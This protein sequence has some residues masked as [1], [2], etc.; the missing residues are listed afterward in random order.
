MEQTCEEVPIAPLLWTCTTD[1]CYFEKKLL[2]LEREVD[3]RPKSRDNFAL[4]FD[5]AS[6]VSY[7]FGPFCPFSMVHHQKMLDTC[8]KLLGLSGP[9][10][11]STSW[12][13][14]FTHEGMSNFQCFT[15]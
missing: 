9:H 2:R 8:G 6:F 3:V 7:L 12:L 5:F 1:V 13:S 4:Y 11:R 15:G 14:I 10:F